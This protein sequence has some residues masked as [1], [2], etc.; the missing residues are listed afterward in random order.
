VE[1]AERI[2][3]ETG[4]DVKALRNRLRER[5]EFRIRERR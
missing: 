1:T 5:V 2:R 4:P 3:V